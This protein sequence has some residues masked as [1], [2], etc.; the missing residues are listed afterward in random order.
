MAGA[1]AFIKKDSS[2]TGLRTRLKALR[3]CPNQVRP[4]SKVRN[5]GEAA[6]LRFV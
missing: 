3:T 2:D 5:F 1:S 6:I 4:E